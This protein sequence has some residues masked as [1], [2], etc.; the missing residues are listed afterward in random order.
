MSDEL[1]IGDVAIFD[2]GITP[3]EEIIIED[4]TLEPCRGTKVKC[5]KYAGHSYDVEYLKK[6]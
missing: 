5:A 3:P 2:N 6:K 1:E 4:F